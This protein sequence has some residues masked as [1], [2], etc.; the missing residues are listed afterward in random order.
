M[1]AYKSGA[2]LLASLALAIRPKAS[3]T[4]SKTH[5]MFL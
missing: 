3:R 5:E 4:R 1:M 2:L